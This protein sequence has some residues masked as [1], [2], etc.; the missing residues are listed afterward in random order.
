L[1]TEYA[2]LLLEGDQ[3]L[4]N[5]F[6][7]LRNVERHG[8]E[9]GDADEGTK[10]WLSPSD[11]GNYAEPWTVSPVARKLL[12]VPDGVNF[13]MR[14]ND[15]SYVQKIADCY[16]YCVCEVFDRQVMA[17]FGYDVCVEIMNPTAFFRRVTK[18]LRRLGLTSHDHEPIV[19]ACVYSPP[20]AHYTKQV[21][22]PPYLLKSPRYAYQRE[23]RA[24][25]QPIHRTIEPTPMRPRGI[26][27]YCRAVEYARHHL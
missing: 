23:V 24:L 26:A 25:W 18:E 1:R 2:R 21:A 14:D 3:L 20:A 17:R 10:E 16:V 15:L 9:I 8:A 12:S 11:S 27:R 5:T 6:E 19:R 13:E 4:V 22:T 7:S